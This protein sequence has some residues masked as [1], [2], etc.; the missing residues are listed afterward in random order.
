MWN[1]ITIWYS[2]GPQV[3]VESTGEIQA[4]PIATA[5]TFASARPWSTSYT[6]ESDE[7]C[8]EADHSDM[9]M[10]WVDPWVGLGWFGSSS[11]KYEL[12]PNSTGK[13]Y[14]Q[15]RI[16]FNIHHFCISLGSAWFTA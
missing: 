14:F 13:Y 15:S 4:L 11:V 1:F 8:S 3:I 6:P 12:L 16:L 9:A 2:R 10:G 7:R 5:T